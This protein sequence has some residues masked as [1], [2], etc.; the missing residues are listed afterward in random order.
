MTNQTH[1]FAYGIAGDNNVM[2][3]GAVNQS[4]STKEEFHSGSVFVF[5]NV[6]G[7][8]RS[9][10][11]HHF[12]DGLDFNAGGET[13][14]IESLYFPLANG[15]DMMKRASDFRSACLNEENALTALNKARREK[16]FTFG[17]KEEDAMNWW[18][19]ARHESMNEFSRFFHNV[20]EL[21]PEEVK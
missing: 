21:L 6:T 8:S 12:P 4:P 19:D 17:M 2:V 18:Q 1:F 3:L 15:L 5:E 16:F 10:I 13:I 9:F 11:G 20:I 14:Q 7:N